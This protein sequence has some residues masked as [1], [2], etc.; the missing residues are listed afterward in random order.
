MKKTYT[1]L[2][3]K[4]VSK[5]DLKPLPTNDRLRILRRIY[6]LSLN[7]YPAGHK[8]LENYDPSTFRIRQGNYRILYRVDEGV[9][10]VL[11]VRVG[12]RKDIYR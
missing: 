10:K 11:V 6:K 5:K 4:R 2:I 1:V 3:E 9:L 12:H 7:P 8:K